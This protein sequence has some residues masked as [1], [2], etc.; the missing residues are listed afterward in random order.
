[1]INIELFPGAGGQESTDFKNILIKMY[2]NFLKHKNIKFHIFEPEYNKRITII[3]CEDSNVFKLLY[4]ES[5]IHRLVR[6]SPFDEQKRRYSSFVSVQVYNTENK[7]EE[8][9]NPVRSYI[10]DPYKAVTALGSELTDKVEDVLNGK[11]ELLG[12]GNEKS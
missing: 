5:G 12:I 2:S 3:E 6:I 1:M 7:L 11:L 4:N 10:L 8:K 9:D